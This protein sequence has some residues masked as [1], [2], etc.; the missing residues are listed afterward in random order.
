MNL[1]SKQQYSK[2]Q[3]A[4]LANLDV[5]P[6][7]S[8]FYPTKGDL[9]FTADIQYKDEAAFIA[10]DICEWPGTPSATYLSRELPTVPYEPGFFAFREGPLIEATFQKIDKQFQ[11]RP[12]LLIVDGHGTAHP[13]KMGLASWLGVKLTIPA[14]GIAKEHLL[15]RQQTPDL[16]AGSREPVYLAGEIVGHELRTQDG[17]NPVFVSA[18]NLVSQKNAVQIAYELRSAYR[19]IEPIRRADQVARLFAKQNPPPDAY[20]L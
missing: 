3:Q 4:L 9:V 5:P 14:I 8:G 2:I 12:D 19:I 20:I 15:P 1:N 6:G 16:I 11:V 13:R 17:V 7:T 18:G 10:V